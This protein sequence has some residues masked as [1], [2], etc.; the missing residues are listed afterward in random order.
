VIRSDKNKV[1]HEMADNHSM[2]HESST[3]VGKDVV[4]RQPTNDEVFIG[5]KYTDQ[6]PTAVQLA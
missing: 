3:L 5:G 6:I 4:L 1:W 2:P